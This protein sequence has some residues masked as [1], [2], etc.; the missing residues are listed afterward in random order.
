MVLATLVLMWMI[1]TV[2]S[3]AANQVHWRPSLPI[4]FRV[5]GLGF[6]KISTPWLVDVQQAL[7][8]VDVQAWAWFGVLILSLLSA[9]NL[10]WFA[11]LVRMAGRMLPSRSRT[12]RQQEMPRVILST[13]GQAA[14]ASKAP[15]ATA[16]EPAFEEQVAAK[17]TPLKRGLS[18]CTS[19]RQ[20]LRSSLTIGMLPFTRRICC[21]HEIILQP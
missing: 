14:R 19:W 8:L 7:R 15:C 11:K 12:E 18:N 3:S 20:A 17:L 5:Y 16:W 21:I 13:S 6:S 2:A 4:Y 1:Q 10:F 9:L